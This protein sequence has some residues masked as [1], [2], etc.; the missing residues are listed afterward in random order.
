MSPFAILRVQRTAYT[1]VANKPQYRCDL[2]NGVHPCRILSNRLLCKLS[3]R[4]FS[5]YSLFRACFVV[6][7]TIKHTTLLLFDGYLERSILNAPRKFYS[8]RI[9]KN[10]SLFWCVFL[11]VN[12]MNIFL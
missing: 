11:F 1:H 2:V 7:L 10:K 8:D 9:M 6:E 5:F 12:K 3:H 4:L